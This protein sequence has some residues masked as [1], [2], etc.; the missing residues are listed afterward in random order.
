MASSAGEAAAPGGAP[1]AGAAP[2]ATLTRRGASR[3]FAGS[4][5]IYSGDATVPADVVPGAI[6]RVLDERGRCLGQ[7]FY[8][9]ASKIQLRRLVG[10]ERPIDADFFRARIAAAAALRRQLLPGEHSYRVVHGD[11]DGLPGLIVDRYGDY[12]VVQ[13]LVPAMDQRRDLLADLLMDEFGCT[14]IVNRSDSSVRALEGLPVEKGILRGTVPDQVI[15]REGQVEFAVSLLQGQKTGAFL[16]QR[17][18]HIVAGR[19]ARG[20]ALDCFSYVGGFA[21]QMARRS[22]RVTA[23]ESSAAAAAA[24]RA[25]AARNGLANVDVVEDNAFDFLRSAEDDGRR[26]D[27]IVL[28]PPAFARNKAAVAGATRGYKEINLRA[29]RLL[30]PGGTLVTASCS[31]HVDEAAFEAILQAAAADARRDVQVLERRGAGRDH[32]VLLGL[33]ETRY[34]KCFVLRAL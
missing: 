20:E 8:S 19:Y 14:G 10:D 2:T 12:L 24:I 1:A 33:R 11:G 15:C 28:D 6:V 30:N 27:T 22:T 3:W 9:R 18:N 34:L 13:F 26:F 23:V 17:E 25:N 5:W 4:P 31:H 32:P 29:L 7:A 16:D 21:L